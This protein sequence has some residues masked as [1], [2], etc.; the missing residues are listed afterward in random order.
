MVGI[1][2]NLFDCLSF[3]KLFH[4]SSTT[5]FGPICRNGSF[6]AGH[7]ICFDLY[8]LDITDRY[9][10]LERNDIGINMCSALTSL[11]LLMAV[12]T[13][14]FFLFVIL[15]MIFSGWGN[16]VQE[17]ISAALFFGTLLLVGLL[18]WPVIC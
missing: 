1:C 13:I 14:F 12:A 4:V 16:H 9:G 2:Y 5:A 8:R 18:L 10:D 6:G 3:V 11:N 15:E 17:L 7:V